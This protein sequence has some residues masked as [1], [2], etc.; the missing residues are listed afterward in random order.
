M[1]DPAACS[2]DDLR[3]SQIEAS[4]SP[5][6]DACAADAVRLVA[7]VRRLRLALEPFAARSIGGYDA[8]SKR[9]LQITVSEGAL[10]TA[11]LTLNSDWGLP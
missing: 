7:E 1:S 2:M 3:L 10:A 9:R 8:R 11:W 5:C 6:P 4:A